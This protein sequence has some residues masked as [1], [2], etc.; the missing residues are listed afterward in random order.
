MATY[1]Y[2]DKLNE[3]YDKELH[4]ILDKIYMSFFPNKSV[5]R[6][7]YDNS[8][9]FQRSGRDLRV[10]LKKP[11]NGSV[12]LFVSET[13]EEKIRSASC[14][15]Y[16]DILIEY[17]SNKEYGTLG[18]IYTS[19]AD[20]LSYVKQPNGFVEVFIFSMQELKRW[21]M[22]NWTNYRDVETN[23]KIGASSYT[24]V[25]KIIPLQ[26]PKFQSFLEAHGFFHKRVER[27]ID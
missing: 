15:G 8:L 21:F 3:S 27:K 13:I 22:F 14:S 17:L 12:D 24:T 7:E 16:D 18:W 25:N 9:M 1:T 23:T 26:D 4:K 6:L 10:V 5:V 20:W 2:Q 19:E 11:G